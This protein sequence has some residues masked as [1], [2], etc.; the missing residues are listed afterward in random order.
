M[1]L[2]VRAVESPQAME[3][4]VTAT[5]SA[6]ASLSQQGREAFG[7]IG[8]VLRE[9]RAWICQERVFAPQGALE[10]LAPIR[11]Q[12]YGELADPVGPSWLVAPGSQRRIAGVQVHAIRGLPRPRP[13]PSA[14]GAYGRVFELDGCRWVTASGLSAP[15]A[16][17]PAQQARATFHK[18]QA[19][20]ARAGADMRSVA[21]TWIFMDDILGWYSQ[22][23]QAR[24]GFFRDCGVIGGRRVRGRLP[25]STGIGVSPARGGK[26]LLDLFAVV[27]GQGTVKRYHAAGKQQSAYEYGSAFSRA[28]QIRSPAGQTVFVSGTAAIDAT[29]ASCFPGDPAAQIR[30]TIENALAVLA[31]MN[32]RPAD[33][34][35]AVA[36]C[37][38]PRVRKLFETRSAA[39]LPWPWV[40]LI[41]DICR[42]DLLF[43]IEVTACPGA[44]KM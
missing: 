33:V 2:D 39:Q 35:Q 9:H 27:G 31:E 23:N 28:S 11:A 17:S 36:Y 38:N 16:G 14:T 26:C 8:D 5:P 6:S 24:T 44:G 32:C 4:Y 22:F 10:T 29:G 30:M 19:L 42:A 20:L 34:V 37:A 13:L 40:T 7:G 1:G 3:M 25:A 12:A 18:A 41:G 43:E 15:E 21:R